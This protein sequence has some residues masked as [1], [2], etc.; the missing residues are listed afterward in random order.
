MLAG[1][2]TLGAA[3]LALVVAVFVGAAGSH[4]AVEATC[5][6]EPATIVGTE[7]SDT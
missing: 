2:R 3:L 4:A 6:G 1:G 5:M 7:N